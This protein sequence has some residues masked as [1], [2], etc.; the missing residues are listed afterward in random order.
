MDRREFLKAGTGG[1]LVLGASSCAGFQKVPHASHEDAPMPDMDSYLVRVDSGME[2][3]SHW[4][5]TAVNPEYPGDREEADELGRNALRSLYMTAMFA[6]LP[7]ADQLHP[8]MQERIWKAMPGMDAAMSGMSR[9]LGSRSDA[10][11]VRVQGALRSPKGPGMRIAGAIDDQAELCGV[12]L[13]RRI[14][15]QRLMADASWRLSNQPPSLIVNETL[16]RVTKAGEVDFGREATQDWLAGQVGE[17]VFWA[18][19][20]GEGGSG[21]EWRDL[22]PDS[23]GS[24]YSGRSRRTKWLSRGAKLMGIGVLVGGLAVAGTAAGAW[25]L[26]FVVTAGAVLIV[27][28]LVFLIIGLTKPGDESAY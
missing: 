7:R 4:S 15:T 25:P 22:Q 18:R 23:R 11:L 5:P 24:R 12:S 21:E 14:Q 16:G 17:R 13:S 10:E 1:F 20:Q 26:V 6:D 8:G 28:G 9:Y 3:I 27:V 2:R 19:Q